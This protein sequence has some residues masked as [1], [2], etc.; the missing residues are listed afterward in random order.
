MSDDAYSF[1]DLPLG[2]VAGGRTVLVEGSLI[3]G[4]REILLRAAD[5]GDGEGAILVATNS[6]GGRLLDYR[7]EA[8]CAD[9]GDRVRIVDCVSAQQGRDLDAPNATGVSSPGDLTGI[10]MRTAEGYDRLEADGIDRVRVGLL[11]VSTILMYADLRRTSRFVHVLAG[12]VA[13]AGGLGVL[14]LDSGA[15]E[16]RTASTIRQLCDGRVELRD[17]DAGRELR[18]RGLPDQPDGW[19][20]VD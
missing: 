10:G 19:T 9:A 6:T 1:P 8:G 17:G 2:P 20:P 5:P 11:S 3:D 16:E 18:V 7:S 15:H 14:A 13:S 4:V 12:R